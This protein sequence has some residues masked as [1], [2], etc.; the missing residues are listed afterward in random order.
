[1]KITVNLNPS[2]EIHIEAGVLQTQS[3]IDFCKTQAN[4]IVIITD[5]NVYPLYAEALE[6]ELKNN[7]CH[8]NIIQVPHGEQHKT[9]KTKQY[10][11]DQMLELQCGRDTC[12]IAIGGGVITDLAGFVAATYCRGIPAIY[13]PTTLLAMVDAS[14]GGKTGVNT[15]FG[16][17][18]IG[19][20]TQPKAVFIDTNTLKTLPEKEIKNGIVEMIKHGIIANEDHFRNLY[21]NAEKILKLEDECLLDLINQSCKTKCAVIEKDEKESGLRETLNFGHTIG[22]ALETITNH[23]LSHGEAVAIG[24]I[25]E[26]K[27]LQ[28]QGI[29][30]KED[31]ETIQ[32]LFDRFNISTVYPDGISTQGIV[33][34]LCLDKKS[35]M[36]SP[37]FVSLEKMGQA[38]SCLIKYD[39]AFLKSS[40]EAFSC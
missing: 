27:L 39:D 37:R 26:A 30:T 20:F 6:A 38:K 12:V 19:T 4:R 10:I 23:Q 32:A 7:Q 28:K 17:N 34:S 31:I 14:I 40:I 2:Y 16:K 11:E 3:L 25:A 35:R 9:R 29:I 24:I 13:I 5:D 36:K 18:M 21:Q 1:M 8:A 33:D 15:S 22:H